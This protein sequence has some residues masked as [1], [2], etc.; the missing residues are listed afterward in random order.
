MSYEGYVQIMCKKGHQWQKDCYD[1]E[2]MDAER[3][4]HCRSKAVWYNCVD[5]TNGSFEDG[6]R[7]DGY[8]ELKVRKKKVC[9][10]CKRELETIYY[11]PKTK[12]EK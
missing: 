4:P 1:F 10:C 7:I 6:K 2:S 8:V 9:R 5:L 11:I 3:C 12:P